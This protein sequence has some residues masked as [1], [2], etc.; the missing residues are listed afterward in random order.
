M[1]DEASAAQGPAG[2]AEKIAAQDQNLLLPTSRTVTGNVIRNSSLQ[3]VDL[4]YHFHIT[5][6]RF[7]ETVVAIY[8]GEAVHDRL[9][10][11][12]GCAVPKSESVS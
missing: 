10:V 1:G 9:F 4:L 11:L 5:T 8:A 6:R 7:N 3:L 2:C 12:A